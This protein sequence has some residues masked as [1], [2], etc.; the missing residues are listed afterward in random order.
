MLANLFLR[1]SCNGSN[2]IPVFSKDALECLLAYDW[3]GNVRELE[4]CIQRAVV[5]GAGETI[6]WDDVII[7]PLNHRIEPQCHNGGL[8][9]LRLQELER[10]A[11]IE[12]LA[13]ADGN[14][15][16]AAKVLGIGVSTIYRKLR[17]YSISSSNCLGG[18][19]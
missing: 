5:L 7:T 14:K 17:E 1:K 13:A 6:H 2:P 19:V 12:A 15:H 4:N 10:Q 16:V 18:T 11:I 8:P 9:L 3:P